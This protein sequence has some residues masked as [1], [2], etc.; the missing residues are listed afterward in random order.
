MWDGSFITDLLGEHAYKIVWTILWVLLSLITISLLTVMRAK[1]LSKCVF[2]S[3]FAHILLV[4]H[5]YMTNLERASRPGTDGVVSVTLRDD[6]LA[7]EQPQPREVPAWDKPPTN[8]KAVQPEDLPIPEHLAE[9]RQ[10]IDAET[11]TPQRTDDLSP[12]M[13]TGVPTEVAMADELHLEGDQPQPIRSIHNQTT[14]SVA[15]EIEMPQAERRAESTPA[16]PRADD[17]AR[18][19][20]VAGQ[21]APLFRPA[22]AERPR[23]LESAAPDVQ[24]LIDA[25]DGEPAEAIRAREDITS[26]TTNRT[27]P[28]IGEALQPAVAP[29]Q[30]LPEE[31]AAATPSPGPDGNHRGA[32]SGAQGNQPSASA[33][34]DDSHHSE[35]AGP[36]RTARPKRLANGE[37]LPDIY[38]L[39]MQVDRGEIARRNGGNQRTEAAVAAALKWLADNQQPDGRWDADKHDA[40]RESR[41][42][43]HDR[44]GAGAQ[45]DTGVTALA[46]LAFMAAGNTHLEGEYRKNVQHGLEFLLKSQAKNGNMAG[47]AKTFAQMYC[48]GMA[49]LAIAEAYALTGDERLQWWVERAIAYT[50]TSQHSTGGGWRYRPG[51]EGDMSQFGWQVMALKAGEAGGIEIPAKTRE[52]MLRF[53]SRCSSGRHGG[54]ASYRPREDVTETMTAEA[55]VCRFF[56]D[57][58]RRDPSVDEAANYLDARRPGDGRANLYYWYYGTLAMHQVGGPRWDR[59]NA[60][61]QAQLLPKQRKAGRTAGSW[62]PGSTLWGG[63]GGRVYSTAM[64][65]LCL[66]AYYRFAAPQ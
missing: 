1:P 12:S 45:A 8:E 18:P 64:G 50:L 31:V 11:P 33:G 25:A 29:G 13:A 58:N 34:S 5:A 40:G 19:S 66:E 38:R 41:V 32:R 4:G 61:L 37:P 20:R 17:A 43:G 22:Q 27:L 7:T 10:L 44:D 2:L 46:V 16:G 26:A 49:T 56:L 57:V 65:A 6:P 54:L 51:D 36:T 47:N 15:A 42:F 52:G 3:L 28:G 48:H 63:Y 60:A 35:H 62:D 39:R 53:L 55:L 9:A 59:W 23:E 30:E 24:R 14:G 21:N